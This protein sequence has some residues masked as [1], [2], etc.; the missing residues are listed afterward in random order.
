MDA[1]AHGAATRK[2]FEASTQQSRWPREITVGQRHRKE[3]GDLLAL[4]RS[5]NDRG[6]LIH[7][8]AVTAHNE[9]I[10][11]ERRLRAWQLGECKLNAAPI[12]VTVIDI[13]SIRAGERDENDPALRLP[14]TPSEAVAIARA[15]RPVIEAEAKER[16][17]KGGRCKAAKRRVADEYDAAQERGEIGQS[18]ARKDLVPNGNEVVPSAADLGLSAKKLVATCHKLRP[19]KPV[20]ASPRRREG[21]RTLAKAEAIVEAA[22][23]EPE[24]FSSLVEAMDRT[25]RVNGPLKR[26]QN[27]LAT[28]AIKA[29]PPPLPMHGP[30]RAGII[31]PPWASEP[32]VAKDH[33][34][35]GYYPYPTVIQSRSRRCLCLPSWGRMLRYGF[36][37]RIFT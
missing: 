35:R 23:R 10:A 2:P 19:A 30:Y 20:T 1:I 34:A 24:K 26:L 33:G 3:F 8:I 16:Q 18:G 31:D 37:S 28:A 29:E 15:L 12:P 14:F 9:L 6:G 32:D 25:G 5:I 36:G 22:E 17:R 11:G 4:A 21:A 27:I 7:P 13:D